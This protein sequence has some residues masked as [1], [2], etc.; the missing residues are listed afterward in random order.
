VLAKYFLVC[1][2]M[3]GAISLEVFEGYGADTFSRP[4]ALFNAQVELLVG[5]LTS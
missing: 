4:A 2:S 3:I 5:V 1:S